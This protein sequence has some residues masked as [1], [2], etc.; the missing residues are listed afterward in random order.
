MSIINV[1]SPN[2]VIQTAGT[3]SAALDSIVK[4]GSPTAKRDPFIDSWRGIFHIIML[5]DHLPFLLPQTLVIIAGFYEWIGY[6]TV[7]EG[8]VFLSG[9]VSGLVY[10]RVKREK[11]NR[12]MWCKAMKRA[13]VIYLCYVLAVVL[14]LALVKCIGRSSLDWLGWRMLFD[15]SWP[16]ASAK[17]A[18]LLYQPSFLEILPMYSLLLVV[19]P[20]ILKQLERGNLVFVIV[21]SVTIWL[22]AQFGIRNTLLNFLSARVDVFFGYFDSL[23][24]QILFVGGL[25]CGHKSYISSKPWLSKSYVLPGLALIFIVL[26]F[27]QHH[28]IWKFELSPGWVDRSTVGLIRL[29]NFASVV[30]LICKARPLIEK[31]ISW[32]GF[33]FLSRHSLQVFAFHLYPIYLLAVAF[34]DNLSLPFALQLAFIAICIASLFQIAFLAEGFRLA[35]E[36]LRVRVPRVNPK[37]FGG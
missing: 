25:I 17:V 35:V 36:N 18:A 16:I 21:A 22:L 12:A 30:F 23:A 28:G 29:V 8:F 20:P 3:E 14:L 34:G 5:I 37:S 7:A 27:V 11:G 32:S 31:I 33:A 24:W 15:L 6:V 2:K 13:G 1:H 4:V 19:T 10:T 9:F 26:C